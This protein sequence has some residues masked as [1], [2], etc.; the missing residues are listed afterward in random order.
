VRLIP[1]SIIELTKKQNKKGVLT[2]EEYNINHKLVPDRVAAQ[3]LD[4]SRFPDQSQINELLRKTDESNVNQLQDAHHEPFMQNARCLSSTE[5]SAKELYYFY[6]KQRQTIEAFFKTCKNTYHIKN[7]RTTKFYGIYSFLWIVFITHNMISW[8]KSTVFQDSELENAG[9]K[10]LVEKL[11]TIPA[12]VRKTA[13]SIQ[14]V[15]PEI[16][17]LARKFVE[18]MKP[19]YKSTEVRYQIENINVLHNM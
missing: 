9:T 13:E 3:I 12:E 17:T 1:Y 11:G 7:L 19:K 2:Y 10:T 16:S 8:M 5:Y 4:M 14:V 18:C 15:L 6:N